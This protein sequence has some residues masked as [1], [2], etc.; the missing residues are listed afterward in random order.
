MATVTVPANKR[1]RLT[2]DMEAIL[3]CKS[4]ADVQF[5]MGDARRKNAGPLQFFRL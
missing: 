5:C 2:N 3:S 4:D 1:E